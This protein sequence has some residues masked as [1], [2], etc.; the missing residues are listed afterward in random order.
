MRIRI[1]IN[2]NGREIQ[3]RRAKRTRVIMQMTNITKLITISIILLSSV[4][5]YRVQ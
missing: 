5:R 1:A 4:K 2:Q 3:Y